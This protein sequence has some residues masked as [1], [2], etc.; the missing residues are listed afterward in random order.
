MG[1]S[2]VAFGREYNVASD[3]VFNIVNVRAAL[4]EFYVHGTNSGAATAAG[5][6]VGGVFWQRLGR[7]CR[8]RKR[9][10]GGVGWRVLD[11]RWL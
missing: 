1:H 10:D 8:G 2:S 5:C 7:A 9:R 3:E 11:M 6:V 4:V